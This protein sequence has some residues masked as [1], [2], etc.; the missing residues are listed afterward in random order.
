VR[1]VGLR[2]GG[3]LLGDGLWTHKNHFF[4]SMTVPAASSRVPKDAAL[5]P[6]PL[7]V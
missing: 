7:S 4:F 6:G 3:V 5:P 1:V 2:V